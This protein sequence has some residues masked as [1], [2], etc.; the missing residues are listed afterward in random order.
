MRSLTDGALECH[1]MRGS[2]FPPTVYLVPRVTGT[3]LVER[4]GLSEMLGVALFFM[5][6]DAVSILPVD[7]AASVPPD[8]VIPLY[9][10]LSADVNGCFSDLVIS[11]E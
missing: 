5:R 6:R 7:F 4:V 1:G 11:A 10:S 2:F 9:A 3:R 8:P